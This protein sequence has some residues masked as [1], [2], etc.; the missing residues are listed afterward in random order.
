[1]QNLIFPLD[2]MDENFCSFMRSLKK[3]VKEQEN[4]RG[5]QGFKGL[6][7]REGERNEEYT[8]IILFD[9]WS[10]GEIVKC[11]LFYDR[12]EYEGLKNGESCTT[13]EFHFKVR[14]EDRESFED[15]IV[16]FLG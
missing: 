12:S 4:D 8:E 13:F 16:Q 10:D 1:M 7:L 5:V 6:F 9:D 15:K 3:F 14:K 11:M 2:D